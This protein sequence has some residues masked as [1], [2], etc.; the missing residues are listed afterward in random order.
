MA[1]VYRPGQPDIRATVTQIAGQVGH[2]GGGRTRVRE[3]EHRQ[4]R[5]RHGDRA[6]P[7]VSG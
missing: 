2:V 3:R 6:V 4:A 1:T 7:Q 5:G